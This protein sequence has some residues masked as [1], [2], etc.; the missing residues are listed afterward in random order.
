MD[1]TRSY[2]PNKMIN[3]KGKYFS[4]DR[5]KIVRVHQIVNFEYYTKMSYMEIKNDILDRMWINISD[6]ISH[7][8]WLDNASANELAQW[9]YS[10][11]YSNYS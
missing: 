8:K 10:K 1:S 2:L 6:I 4:I 11:Y 9:I 5:E 3:I 7:Q